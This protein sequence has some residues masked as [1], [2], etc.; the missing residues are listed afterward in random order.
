MLKSLHEAVHVFGVSVVK[1]SFRK[2]LLNP[3]SLSSR[4]SNLLM[5]SGLVGDL[6]PE[7]GRGETPR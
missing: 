5:P 7:G 4:R 2:H 3:D 1:Q 6:S